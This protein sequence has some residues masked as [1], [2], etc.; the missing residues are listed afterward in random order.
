MGAGSIISKGAKLG[1][2]VQIYPQCYIGED[3]EIGNCTI[4]YPGVKIYR[5]C[6]IGADC[7]I[8]SNSVIGADGFGF[9]QMEDGTFKKIPQIGNVIVEDNC[10]IGANTTIDR[11]SIGSTIIKKGVKL[12]NLIQIAHNVEVGENSVIAAMVGIAGSVKV[13]K[14]CML[15]G[16][17]GVREHITIADRTMVVAQAGITNH[18]KEEGR[19][20]AGSPA[21]DARDYFKA[22]AYFRKLHLQ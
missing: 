21:I 7:I 4:I 13:G 20:L 22:Y 5:G 14:N 18:I 19:T 11:A 2:D 9:T 17:C 8:H 3:V 12:D 1:N 10:E 15:G 6:K 16:Q